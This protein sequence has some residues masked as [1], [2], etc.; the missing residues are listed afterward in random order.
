MAKPRFIFIT[1]GVVS[2]LGKGIS[3]S[4]IGALLQARG[5]SVRIRK[6]DPYINVDPGTMSP[7]QHGEV[8]VTDDG[9]E[10][11]LDLGHYERF[12][13]VPA[14]QSDNITTG[15]IYKNVIN[16]EREGFYLGSTVQ[17]I[18][19]VTDEI[20]SFITKDIADCDFILVEIGGTV[21][22]IESLPFLESIRQFGNEIGKNRAIYIHLTLVP[23]I[24]TSNE[25][26]TKP[27]QHSVK[28]LRE[29]GIQPNILLCRCDRSI[30]EN[31]ID[32]I[33]LFCNVKSED[34]IQA[35]DVKNIYNVPLVYHKEKLDIQVLKHFNIKPNKINLNKW[36]RIVQSANNV[37]SNIN[38]G[39]V[40]KY[41]DLPDAYKSLNE[42]IVH[43]GLGNKLGVNIHWINSESLNNKS[44]DSKFS[45]ING[46][47]VPGGFGERGISGKIKAINYARLNGVPFLGICLGLQLAVIEFSR[48][49]LNIKS[50]NSS[51]FVNTENNVI[52]LLK[53]WYRDGKKEIRSKSSDIG[54]SMRLGSYPCNILKGSL[55]YKIYNKITVHERHRHRYEVNSIYEDKLKEKG[56][57]FSGKSPD[58]MLP[59]IIEITSHPWFVGVQFHPEL[60]SRPFMPHPIFKSFISAVKKVSKK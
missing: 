17:V 20:K 54:G 8:F 29:I 7:Y 4:A 24:N 31:E 3:A 11:D 2:S 58:S 45:N 38:I 59:E 46:I 22:D 35:L 1:G 43:G 49:V 16:K 23:Y 44:L 5:Y 30:E 55:A 42:A 36:K 52:G 41:T 33:A 57:I 21:G 15:R 6:L 14:K 12:T 60:K 32:K 26:K 47:I 27:T 10:T 53:E 40:G 37:K 18:P 25:Q 50:A 34:V 39:I 51:E 48:N 56:M 13:G 19:H 9:A 28:E